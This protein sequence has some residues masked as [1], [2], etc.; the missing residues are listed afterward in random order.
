MAHRNRWAKMEAYDTLIAADIYRD[1]GSLE[2]RFRLADGSFESLWLSVLPWDTPA[3]K[4]YGALKVSSVA[5][6]AENGRVVPAGSEEE[7]DILVRLR[8]FLRS[9][10]VDVPFAHR[11][12]SESFVEK[13]VW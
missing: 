1:G 8:D 2:A 6:G 11:T 7:R 9:P 5:D 4:K 10:K 13:V 12:D 3:Q